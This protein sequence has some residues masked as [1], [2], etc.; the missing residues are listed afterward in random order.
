MLVGLV[1][2]PATTIAV[3][4]GDVE[5]VVAERIDPS[6]TFPSGPIP[7]PPAPPF[8]TR[9]AVFEVLSGLRM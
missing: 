1:L 2:G 6:P 8:P 3:V 4:N 9:T 7:F 5:V